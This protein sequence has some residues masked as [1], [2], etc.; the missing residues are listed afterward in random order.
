MAKGLDMML[1]AMG[2]DLDG[3]DLGK[4]MADF[5][6]LKTTV[7]QVLTS[8]DKKLSDNAAQLARMEQQQGEIW[9]SLQTALSMSSQVRV[10]PMLPP[11]PPQEQQPAQTQHTGS[12][13][14]QPTQPLPHLVPPLPQQSTSNG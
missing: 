2:L 13:S 1:K 11:P 6:H 3:L 5:E 14:P 7:I 9:K 8:I 4:I 12:Q 10:V